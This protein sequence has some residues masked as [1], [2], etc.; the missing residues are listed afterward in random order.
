MKTTTIENLTQK[1]SLSEISLDQRPF[2]KRYY[3]WYVEN[4]KNPENQFLQLLHHSNGI[5]ILRINPENPKILKSKSINLNFQVTVNLNRLENKISGKRKRNAQWLDK[6]STLCFM[7]LNFD[8][9]DDEEENFE[10][11]KLQSP[12]RGKLLQI[13]EIYEKTS[14][15]CDQDVRDLLTRDDGFIAIVMPNKNKVDE[16]VLNGLTE[17]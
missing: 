2:T 14:K 3:K 8:H 7:K 9:K 16:D 17:V 15:D 12:V 1:W 13:N 6:N 10:T 5:F 11:I 4:T